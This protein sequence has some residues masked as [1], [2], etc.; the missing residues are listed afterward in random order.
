MG[1]QNNISIFSE[2][3]FKEMSEKLKNE[4]RLSVFFKKSFSENTELIKDKSLFK[5]YNREN[6]FKFFSRC[7][8][9]IGNHP[10]EEY[11]ED[12]QEFMNL[13]LEKEVIEVILCPEDLEIEEYIDGGELYIFDRKNL[14]K[15][16]KYLCF[17]RQI[18]IRKN[19][20]EL[21]K[22]EPWD[23]DED[24]EKLKK[25]HDLILNKKIDLDVSNELIEEFEKQDWWRLYGS[26]DYQLK[27]ALEECNKNNYD[28]ISI[29]SY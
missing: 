11:I 13:L 26:F 28:L 9:E 7:L 19:R 23:D 5:K 14:E 16:C 21:E 29:G 17:S 24:I 3:K 1:T 18:Y 8:E 27:K 10:G 2:K 25:E 22:K 15:I 6:A 12:V 20:S 4:E